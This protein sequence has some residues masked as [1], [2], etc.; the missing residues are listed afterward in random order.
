M[1]I[2]TSRHL[3]QLRRRIVTKVDNGVVAHTMHL[4][5]KICFE[6]SDEFVKLHVLHG[7]YH[8]LSVDCLSVR[9]LSD[10]VWTRCCIQDEYWG[11]FGYGLLG[12]L[13]HFRSVRQGILDDP[14]DDGAGKVK[15]LGSLRHCD[16]QV[17][18]GPETCVVTGA[19]KNPKQKQI[20]NDRS[21]S[22]QEKDWALSLFNDY[23]LNQFKILFSYPSH[24]ANLESTR[25]L[26]IIS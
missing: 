26:I 15:V 12:L 4:T 24:L 13:R 7:R 14:A 6:W 25:K 18:E 9:L 5:F 2:G 11:C 10:L 1:E 20:R 3:Q 21:L 22:D 17:L 16:L 23:F 19:K 8:V